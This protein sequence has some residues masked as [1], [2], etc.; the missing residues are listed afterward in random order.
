MHS[1]GTVHCAEQLV[2]VINR[3]YQVHNQEAVM[4]IDSYPHFLIRICALVHD[5]AHIPFGHTLE[6]EG[7]LAKGEWKDPKRAELWLGNDSSASIIKT[8]REFL[9]EL[10]VQQSSTDQVVE[11]IRRYVLPGTSEEHPD[12]P[13]KDHPMDLEYPFIVDIV[14]NT[15]CADL[16][17][18]L[19]RDMYFCGLR[20]RSGDRVVK[21][22]AVIRVA[23]SSSTAPEDEEF[24]A[25]DTP[26]I[27]KG[28]LVLLAY[29]FEREHSASGNLKSVHKSEILS[30]AIDLLRR[31]FALAEKVYFHRT[32]TAA[33]AMLISAV[34]SSS[35]TLDSLYAESDMGMISRLRTDADVRTKHLAAAYEAR[36]LYKPI[37]RIDYREKREE[38]PQSRKIEEQIYPKFRDPVERKRFEQELET[39]SDL[40][41]GAI[42]I[43]CPESGMNLKQF[44]MLVQ[45]RPNGEIKFLK[46]ILDPNRK[47][48][49]DTINERFAQLW[50]LQVFVDP[51]AMDV[52]VVAKDDV[53]D[54]NSLCESL[55]DLPNDI[56]ELQRQGRPM[57]E[58]IAD[59]VINEWKEAG[60]R[61]VPH[62]VFN[63][64]I[65]ASHRAAG[66][67]LIESFRSHLRVLM[68][69]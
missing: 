46:N 68:E 34:G 4:K 53:R 16:L 19:D 33:S 35:L 45:S 39:I 58:Q 38:D 13:V 40:P 57:R 41:P 30:E 18:Y 48:E 52:S 37:Y 7:H 59:R 1:I 20:E 64:L 47:Q 61:E 14:G 6:N 67:E 60:G 17:D 51:Q 3:N 10:G 42:A 29:R 36:R 66:S 44:E 28:R 55:I 32:K 5:I 65:G 50:R 54:L 2:Q 27:G 12:F 69:S 8:I 49:M 56:P 26:M 63:E 11:D 25:S 43:Y 62:D 22:L 24:Q 23:R 9:A 31:R 21:Y 15:L